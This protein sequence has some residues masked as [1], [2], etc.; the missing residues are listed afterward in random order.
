LFFLS[1]SNLIDALIFDRVTTFFPA[2]HVHVYG[3]SLDE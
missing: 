3:G 1:N 2:T